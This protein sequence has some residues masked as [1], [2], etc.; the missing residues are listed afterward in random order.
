[1]GDLLSLFPAGSTV[2]TDG[3]LLVA[4]CRATDLAAEFETP[5]LVVSEPALRARATE[6][7]TEF[8][9]RWPD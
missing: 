9:A 8:A 5:V 3:G 4:G 1:M 6:Y 7:V 2:D